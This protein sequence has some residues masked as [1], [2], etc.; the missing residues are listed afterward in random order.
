MNLF[1]GH[2]SLKVQHVMILQNINLTFHVMG[3][4]TAL[5]QVSSKF[6]GQVDHKCN[7]EYRERN[8]EI[9]A[10]IFKVDESST[11]DIN[12]NTPWN[13]Y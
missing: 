3:I 1:Q 12:I 11:S 6:G 9:T 4:T 7:S 8:S 10:G 2:F 5:L 13:T